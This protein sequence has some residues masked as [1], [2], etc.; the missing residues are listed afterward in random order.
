MSGIDSPWFQLSFSKC[1]SLIGVSTCFL[2]VKWW[3]SLIEVIVQKCGAKS[4]FQL[5][6]GTKSD[7]SASATKWATLHSA[8]FSIVVPMSCKDGMLVCLCSFLNSPKH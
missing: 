1:S 5:H 7:P 6:V 8:D 3:N 2:I 4:S